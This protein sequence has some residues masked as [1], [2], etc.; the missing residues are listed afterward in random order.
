MHRILGCVR[1]VDNRA[2]A[3]HKPAWHRRPEPVSDVLT[4]TLLTANP[5]VER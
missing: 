2:L 4:A 3:R 1:L 5:S